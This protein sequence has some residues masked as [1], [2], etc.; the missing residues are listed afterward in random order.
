MANQYMSKREIYKRLSL[1]KKLPTP[2]KVALE[3]IRLC[4]GEDSSLLDIAHVIEADPALS[5]E[6]LKYANS[7]IM[8]SRHPVASIQKA[9][10]KIGMNG[11]V[12]LALGFSLLSKYQGG[13]CQAFNY[14]RFWSR[15]LA[16]AVAAKAMAA[17]NS[18][19]DPDELFACGLLSHIGEL[20]LASSYPVE[21]AQ[22]L[23]RETTGKNLKEE[24][25]RAF[26]L[27]HDELTAE[28]LY[29]WGLPEKYCLAAAFHENCV[30][31]NINSAK[32][33]ELAEILYLALQISEICL[34]EL[35]LIR[36]FDF[37]EKLAE[38]LGV[39]AGAFPSFFDTIVATWQEWGYFLQINTQRCPLY[40]QV[41]LLEGVI[42]EGR[43]AQHIAEKLSILAVDDDPM[44][45][46]NLTRMLKNDNRRIITAEDGEQAL[47]LAL[48]EQPEM[49]I[50]DW[51]MP[52]LDGLELC[53]I[54]RRTS[55]TQHIYIVMLTSCEADD[56]L[57][58]A[59][60]AGADDY[61]VKPFTP[62]VL[63]ARIRSGERLARYQQTIHHDREVIQQYAA[64]L[65][66]A[67]RKLQTMAMTDALTGLPN[68]RSAMSRMKDVVAETSRYREKL[69]CIMIDVDHFKQIN[70]TYG[71]D[72]GDL[73][74]KEIARIFS[75]K[76]R[77][78]D[79]VS[80][81]G[82][83]EF[84]VICARSDREDSRQL[85]E[86]LRMAV[87][88]FEIDL[89]INSR[90]KVTISCG[91]ATWIDSFTNDSELIKAADEALYRA[92]QNGRNRVEVSWN[93]EK[94]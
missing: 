50:T 75:S 21:Y 2:S 9:A 22:L 88:E 11:I 12:N 17:V 66:A 80:R 37:L 6:L 74:L 3:L 77:S 30:Q 49:I 78:Y 55:I 67:N 15:S 54:L 48:D 42:A 16:I 19:H 26:G 23:N 43:P 61:V 58:Q 62:K 32:I 83:E 44:T 29:D 36:N 53:K 7:A 82:G 45:L 24:E 60:D 64:Q 91:V 40:H 52:K 69:S 46:L 41:K 79:M 94:R 89:G 93:V 34:L 47:L 51:R 81:I 71:H 39:A 92:K 76:A 70:D 14:N 27:N 68:R 84:L 31:E 28:L 25:D 73:V 87:R 10:I 33:D 38:K 57:V 1:A 86:R 63:E 72:N 90:I 20:A 13:A 18:N 8:G 35:P 5:A 59:F 65:T 85:A 4:H 56:E